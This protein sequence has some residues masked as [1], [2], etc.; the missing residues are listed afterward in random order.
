MIQ[1]IVKIFL[2]T[3]L[4]Q[5]TLQAKTINIDSLVDNAKNK[6]K[7]LFV[8][9]HKTDCGY[10][11]NMREFT[12]ENEIVKNF[13]EKNFIFID[14]NV[15]EKDKV[16]YQDFI[17]TAKEF[18]QEIG[19]DFYPSS[20]FFDS[21][22]EIVFSEVGF[23]DSA[24]NPNEKHIYKI[25]NFINSYSYKDMDFNEYQYKIIEDF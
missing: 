8:W 14:I 9:L 11:E 2:I 12:L 10:C 19:Y 3:L 24:E 21:E 22:K 6:E 25:L 16:I 18:A 17:G 23:V 13:I 7:H 4:F 20:L 15:Y 1:T 5:L